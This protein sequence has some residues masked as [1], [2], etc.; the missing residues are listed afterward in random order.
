MDKRRVEDILAMETK[1][2]ETTRWR[3]FSKF[4][5]DSLMLLSKGRQWIND[6]LKIF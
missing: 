2:M 6:A 3:Y 1:A 5:T 4:R